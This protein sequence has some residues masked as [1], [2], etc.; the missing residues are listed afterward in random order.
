MRLNLSQRNRVFLWTTLKLN[1]CSMVK[2]YW[3]YF[4]HLDLN[5]KK[6]LE[7][8]NDFNQYKKFTQEYCV[9]NI[10]FL[11]LNVRLKDGKIVTHLHVKPTDY[12]QYLH[13]SLDHPN[14]T[15]CSVVFSQTLRISRFCFNESD[16]EQKKEKIRSWF[17]Q[18]ISQKTD[19][20]WNRLYK[21]T[22]RLW[23]KES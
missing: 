14:H 22:D 10:S 19:R 1:S 3:W 8:L 15:K 4:F 11:D 9:E 17:V 20:L 21:R 5:V 23:N 6:F 16:F 18:R 12:H 7:E 13:F 2:V